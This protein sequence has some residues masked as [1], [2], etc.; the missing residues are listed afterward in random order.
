VCVCVCVCFCV[1]VCVCVCV[2]GALRYGV[3]KSTG[4]VF[5]TATLRFCSSFWK[6]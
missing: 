3:P 1:C 5:L 6:A 2:Y 4:D